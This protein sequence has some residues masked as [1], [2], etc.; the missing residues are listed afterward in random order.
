[1]N[2]DGAS[3]FIFN[4]GED[5]SFEHKCVLEEMLKDLTKEWADQFVHKSSRYCN[6]GWPGPCSFSTARAPVGQLVPGHL[7]LG[8]LAHINILYEIFVFSR[9]VLELWP[10]VEWISSMLLNTKREKEQTF[11]N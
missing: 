11:T 1:M 8:L 7:S 4:L 2:E 5:D 6:T 10:V 9:S 3:I